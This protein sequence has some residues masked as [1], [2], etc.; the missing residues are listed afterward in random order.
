[1]LKKYTILIKKFNG[2]F[3][4]L[5]LELNVAAQGESLLE[6]R[7]ELGKAIREYLIFSEKEKIQ[8][9]ALDIDTLR[10]FLMGDINE[11]IKI[12]KDI[13]FAENFSTLMPIYEST[14][15]FKILN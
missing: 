3:V 9:A 14:R 10:E 6:T 8:T 2:D 5:C 4:A 1:M 7:E 11:T 15:S 12:N 13:S